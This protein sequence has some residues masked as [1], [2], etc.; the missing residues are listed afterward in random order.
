MRRPIKDQILVVNFKVYSPKKRGV[1]IAINGVYNKLSD[2]SASYPNYNYNFT[3]M[4]APNKPI[5]TLHIS[6]FKGRYSVS[7]IQ[8][9]SID[10]ASLS[11][12]DITP[13]DMQPTQG[14][15]VLKG[16]ISW[17]KD[18]YFVSSLAYQKGYQAYDNGKAVAIEKVNTAFVGFPLT[19]GK[20]NIIITYKAPGKEWGLYMSGASLVITILIAIVMKRREI[21][22]RKNK[23][24]D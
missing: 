8:V 10:P 24:M 11:N 15:Q 3:F 17:K 14:Y 7:P 19:K 6:L 1:K 22:E 21:Y 12:T 20:H 13:M 23:R 9:Y 4:I 16:N 2:G 18:G 5:D